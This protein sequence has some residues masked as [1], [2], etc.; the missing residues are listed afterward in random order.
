LCFCGS[1]K[2][3]RHCHRDAYRK[4]SLFS[5]NE[6]KEIIRILIESKEFKIA[7]QSI[8]ITT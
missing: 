6:L 8:R 2:K 3:Y 7:Y 4:V 5:Q 1:G